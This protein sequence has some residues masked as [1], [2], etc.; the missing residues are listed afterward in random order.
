MIVTM[1]LSESQDV[2]HRPRN[3]SVHIPIFLR[4]QSRSLIHHF[5]VISWWIGRPIR[6]PLVLKS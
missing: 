4:Q 6:T 5:I 3:I 2:G 1:K